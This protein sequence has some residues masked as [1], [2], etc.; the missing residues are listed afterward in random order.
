MGLGYLQLGQ[1]APTLSG[2]EAQRVKLAAELSRPD[3][4]QTL[5]LLD[6]PTTGLHFEDLRKLLEVLHRLVDLGNSVVVIEHNLDV[7][8]SADWVIDLGPEA[9]S[10]GGQVVTWGTPEQVARYGEKAVKNKRLPRSHTGEVLAPVLEAGPY[11][12]RQVYNF[13]AEAKAQSGDID[14]SDVGKNQKMPWEIDG[15]RWHT[16]TRV[17]RSG[18]PCN[19]DGKV[20]DRVVEYIERAGGFRDTDWNNRGV[21]EIAAPKKTHGWFFH[22]MTSEPWL[23]KL[24]FRTASRTFQHDTLVEQV[25]MTPLNDMHDL[26]IYG[27]DQRV[28]CKN[29]RGPWQ[30][31]ELQVFSMREIDHPEFWEMLDQAIAG[32]KKIADKKEQHPEDVMPWKVLGEK[33]HF[34][35]KGF[36]LGRKRDWPPMLL[37]QL[38]QLLEK[39]APEGNFIWNNQQVVHLFVPGQ[40]EPWATLHTKRPQALELSIIGPSG[41]FTLGRI[42]RLGNSRRLSAGSLDTFKFS[43]SNG[44]GLQKTDPE[45]GDLATFL[46]EHLAQITPTTTA[47]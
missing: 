37:E 24:K 29:L 46:K 27:T 1:A 6:E 3:T 42:A 34:S 31:V 20:V 16:K 25:G 23:V 2:G 15:H 26:P 35:S 41:Q 12:K 11:K 39:T 17:A 36:P 9:G 10:D 43:F 47:V 18:E 28:R 5:Y 19:W 44:E 13:A 33:W 38:H 30:E 8:K 4:G 22:A 45:H 21:V 32:F 14:I 40:K 7:I